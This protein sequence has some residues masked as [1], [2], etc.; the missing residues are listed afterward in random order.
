M[1][2]QERGEHCGWAWGPQDREGSHLQPSQ[3]TLLPRGHGNESPQRG[4]GTQPSSEGPGEQ[5]V[6]SLSGLDHGLERAHLVP[7]SVC[8]DKAG[9]G[10]PK[11]VPQWGGVLAKHRL[12]WALGRDRGDSGGSREQRL[13]LLHGGRGWSTAGILPGGVGRG[14]QLSLLTDS[15]DVTR[16]PCLSP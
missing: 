10:S 2:R 4:G 1:R 3:R 11:S 6:A 8:K 5:P 15:D 13:G 14:P 16:V 12:L 7:E 9:P